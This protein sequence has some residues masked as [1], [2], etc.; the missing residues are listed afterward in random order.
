VYG[1]VTLAEI[2]EAVTARAREHHME[3]F[4]FQSNH[5]GAL[6]DWLQAEAP[7]AEGIIVNPGGLAH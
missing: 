7:G 4:A 2:M 1:K 3:V 6:I 5:E